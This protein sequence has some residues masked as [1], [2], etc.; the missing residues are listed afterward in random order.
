MEILEGK[1]KNQ[2]TK[3]TFTVVIYLNLA[4]T[5]YEVSRH[6]IQADGVP[7]AVAKLNKLV[8]KEE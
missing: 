7:D 1:M 4:G 8:N 6:R 5:D 3:N 2:V